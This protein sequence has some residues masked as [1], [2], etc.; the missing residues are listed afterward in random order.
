MANK[1]EQ[2]SKPVGTSAS[3]VLANPK[4]TKDQKA[5]AGSALAQRPD[6]KKK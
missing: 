5:A 4:S 1:N 3:K 6:K 2:T